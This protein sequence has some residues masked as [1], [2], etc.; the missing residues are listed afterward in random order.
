M[1][2]SKETVAG[3]IRAERNRRCM[4]RK[5]LAKLTGIPVATLGSYENAECNINVASAW[6]I[7]DALGITLGQLAGR[8]ECRES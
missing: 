3:N 6:A 2:Y 1:G 5:E 8:D 4:S 7:C